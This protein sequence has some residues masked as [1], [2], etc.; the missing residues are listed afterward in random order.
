[1]RD[2]N[3]NFFD[4][5]N[6]IASDFSYEGIES[7][8]ISND[9]FNW[10]SVP[11][12]T[13]REYKDAGGVTIVDYEVAT[14][15]KNNISSYDPFWVRATDKAGNTTYSDIIIPR[16]D[17]IKPEKPTTTLSTTDVV[18][19]S[20]DVTIH[21]E[22]LGSG[23]EY[24]IYDLPYDKLG[25]ITLYSDEESIDSLHS[26]SRSFTVTENCTVEFKIIDKVGNFRTESVSIDNIDNTPPE[27]ITTYDF[28]KTVNSN[29]SIL[30][31]ATDRSDIDSYS[32]RY[33]LNGGN[34]QSSD[35][36]SNTTT[37]NLNSLVNGSNK[38]DIKVKDIFGNEQIVTGKY[39][40]EYDDIEPEITKIELLNS[41]KEILQSSS[42]DIIHFNWENSSLTLKTFT[43]DSSS[44]V[45][46]K[47]L[48]HK[49]KT[50]RGEVIL[51]DTVKVSDIR[52]TFLSILNEENENHYDIYRYQIVAIDSAGNQSIKAKEVT[53]RIDRK[54]P[55]IISSGSL[56]NSKTISEI[57]LKSLP[58]ISDYGTLSSSFSANYSNL[59]YSFDKLTW[60]ALP[61]DLT[62]RYSGVDGSQKLYLRYTDGANNISD[63]TS[64]EFIKDTKGPEFSSL[65]Q[66]DNLG[67]LLD[68][69]LSF[70]SLPSWDDLDVDIDTLQYR[71]D[72]T[73]LDL[74]TADGKTQIDVES[75]PEGF[76]YIYFRVKDDVGNYGEST[77]GLEFIV[78]KT[79]PVADSFTTYIKEDDLYKT[80]TETGFSSDKDV[81][82]AP[83][84]SDRVLD[85]DGDVSYY[86]FYSSRDID[87]DF[88][89]IASIF[90]D[91]KYKVTLLNGVTYIKSVAIDYG[92]N[93]SE[94]SKSLP[95]IIDSVSPSNL[96]IKSTSHPEANS[97][98]DTVALDDAYFSFSADAGMAGIKQYHYKLYKSE[99]YSIF[100]EYISEGTTISKLELVGLEE[101]GYNENTS[102]F[103]Y[104]YLG[105]V[106]ESNNG[107]LSEEEVYTFRV[108]L[109]NPKNIRIDSDTHS[110]DK[111]Y[112]SA[113]K[114]QFSWLEP[115]DL[116]GIKKYYYKF[117]NMETFTQDL[118]EYIADPNNIDIQGWGETTKREKI[119]D[120]QSFVSQGLDKNLECGQVSF[121][122]V[123]EDWTGKKNADYHTV[124]F[125]S[126]KPTIEPITDDDIYLSVD[127]E[128]YENFNNLNFTWGVVEDN[129]SGV[130]RL[131]FS[132]YSLDNGSEL[133][134][135]V[136]SGKEILAP[137][138]N[139]FSV[140]GLDKKIKKYRAQLEIFDKA[141]NKEIKH[142]FFDSEG[143]ID[144]A[145]AYSIPFDNE[146]YGYRVVGQTL[147]DPIAELLLPKAL[148]LKQNSVEITK[149]NLDF[150]DKLTEFKN[151]E[152]KLIELED[153][154]LEFMIRGYALK[155][156]GLVLDELG[157]EIF[158]PYITLPEN[159]IAQFNNN[160]LLSSSKSLSSD[161]PISALYT[162]YKQFDSSNNWVIKS[163][164]DLE[165]ILSGKNLRISTGYLPK[166]SSNGRGFSIFRNDKSVSLVKILLNSNWKILEGDFVGSPADP[167]TIETEN[168]SIKVEK[169]IL[170]ENKIIIADGELI[171]HNQEFVVSGEISNSVRFK[172]LEI[173]YEGIVTK[174][175]SF[176]FDNFSYDYNGTNFS[177]DDIDFTEYGFTTEG[178]FSVG[179]Y[180]YRFSGHTFSGESLDEDIAAKL[181]TRL[182]LD[183]SG[184]SLTATDIEVVG[185]QIEINGGILTLTDTYG[186]ETELS[187]VVKPLIISSLDF[188]VIDEGIWNI[189]NEIKVDHSF[190]S[191]L[192]VKSLGLGSN[193]LDYT[194]MFREIE[195][196]LDDYVKGEPFTLHNLLLDRAGN[197]GDS[198][199][200]NSHKVIIEGFNY[201][202]SNLQYIG[203]DFKITVGSLTLDTANPDE[204]HL[205]GLKFKGLEFSGNG[206]IYYGA[207][208]TVKQI[209][210]D[211]WNYSLAEFEQRADGL[212][213]KAS[214]SLPEEYGRREI[215]FNDFNY[216]PG[217]ISNSGI[218]DSKQFINIGDWRVLA[219]SISVDKNIINIE[220]GEIR[221]FSTMGSQTLLLSSIKLD[222]NGTIAETISEPSNINFI[223]ENGFDVTASSYKLTDNGILLSGQILFPE[224]LQ[225]PEGSVGLNY[226]DQDVLLNG[227]GEII[228]LKEVDE[229]DYFVGAIP[230][231]GY[232]ISIDSDGLLTDE[233]TLKIVGLN[234]HELG[235]IEYYASGEIKFGGEDFTP[236]SFNP[237]GDEVTFTVKS[238]RLTDD[239]I[240][241]S[242]FV[243][244]PENFAAEYIYFDHLTLHGDG[245]VTSD[246]AVPHLE[247]DAFNTHFNFHDIYLNGEGFSIGEGNITLPDT[248]ENKEVEL[249]NFKINSD[250]S[251][252]LGSSRVDP[253]DM[254][255]YTFYID[256]LGF[257][258]LPVNT[259][260]GI[261]FSGGVRLPGD[262]GVQELAGKRF[263]IKEL[264]VPYDMDQ[265]ELRFNLSLDDSIDFR[266]F[267][268]WDATIT[269]ITVDQDFNLIVNE[270]TV[271]LPKEFN[272]NGSEKPQLKIENITIIPEPTGDE[273]YFEV[274]SIKASNLSYRYKDLD[275]A[276]QE[277]ALSEERGLEIT[278]GSVFIP[279]NDPNDP[280]FPE[281]LDNTTLSIHTLQ[282]K[283]DFSVGD[284][285]VSASK[286]ESLPLFDELFYLEPVPTSDSWK[287][288][289]IKEGDDLFLGASARAVLGYDFPT[290]IAGK[291]LNIGDK[292]D[293]FGIKVNVT[294]GS[295]ERFD[296]QGDFVDENGNGFIFTMLENTVETK[297]LGLKYAKETELFELSVT[298]TSITLDAPN[299]PNF[300][301]NTVATVETFTIDQ[302]GKVSNFYSTFELEDR[303]ELFAGIYME[304]WKLGID[305]DDDNGLFTFSTL[306][307]GVNSNLIE[308]GSTFPDGIAGTK[309]S[310]SAFSIDSNGII[311]DIDF[312]VTLSPELKLFGDLN[313]RGLSNGEYDGSKG[314]NLNF[315]K[316]DDGKS[317]IIDLT[318]AAK[319]PEGDALPE[320]IAGLEIP[321]HTFKFDATGKILALDMGVSN[322][323]I[324]IYG[325]LSL[326][327]G[328]INVLYE[329]VGTNDLVFDF[330][331]SIVMP[332][333][334]KD[335]LGVDKFN[336]NDLKVSTNSGLI[337]F[338]AGVEGNITAPL[339]AGM[340][341]VFNDIT[342]SNS[343]ISLVGQL[344]LPSSLAEGLPE[345]ILLEKFVMDWGGDIID[346]SAGI[347][348]ATVT[349]GGF[350]T[351]IT[352]FVVNADRITMDT[353]RIKLPSQM[354]GQK[355]GF[356]N[357]G[358]DY[359]GTFFGEC[360]LDK[361]E[362]PN[363]AGFKIILIE[364]ALDAVNGR[365]SF[366]KVYCKT[367][368]FVGGV[369]IGI[370]GVEVTPSSLNI[371]GGDIALPDFTVGDGMGFKDIK[372]SFSVNKDSY[373]VK[374]GGKLIVPGMG[375]FGTKVSFTNPS[376][377]Y[378]IG[379][380]QA[381]FSWEAPGVGIPM[382]STGM[383]LNG[384]RGGL[385]FGPPI[386]IPSSLR[387]MF[388][389][390]TRIQLGLT[391]VDST[392]GSQVR[393]DADIWLDITDWDWAFRGDLVVLNGTARAEVLAAITG[394][395]FYGK[396]QVTLAV[397]RGTVQVFVYD[398]NGQTIVSGTADVDFGIEKGALFHS[399]RKKLWF[400]TI[401]EVNI[402]SRTEWLAKGYAQFGRFKKGSGWVDGIKGGINIAWFNLN[403]FANSNGKLDLWGA[404]QYT[405]YNPFSR[406]GLSAEKNN[407][408]RIFN[409][410]S[411]GTSSIANSYNFSIP[412][413]NKTKL[414]R[415]GVSSESE[416]V[417][418]LIFLVNY[419]EG[420][421][422]LTAI[423]ADGTEYTVADPNVTVDRT[424]WGM[425]FIVNKPQAGS[426][427]LR[428]DNMPSDDSYSVTVFGNQKQPELFVDTFGYTNRYITEPLTVSGSTTGMEEGQTVELFAREDMNEFTG[429]KIAQTTLDSNGSFSTKIDPS[430]LVD[431][432][433]Y[434]YVSVDNG[435]DANLIEFIGG[436]LL[437]N[438]YKEPLAA[439][440]NILLSKTKDG[441]LVVSFDKLDSVRVAGYS[442]TLTNKNSGV[443]KDFYL[444]QMT[445]FTIPGLEKDDYIA[446]IKA[447][448]SNGAY[449]AQSIAKEISLADVTENLNNIRTERDSIILETNVGDSVTDT[450]DIIVDFPTTT[451]SSY[452]FITGEFNSLTP[453]Q[454]E[455][456]QSWG[457]YPKLDNS[458]IDITS[459]HE[460]LNYTIAT[461]SYTVPGTYSYILTINNMG[462]LDNKI[463]IPL[464]LK[465]THPP[466]MLDSVSP[467]IWSQGETKNFEIYGSGFVD[468][469]KLLLDGVELPTKD[470]TFGRLAADVPFD[471]KQGNRTITV[472]SP[473]GEENTIDVEVEGPTWS[474]ATFKGYSVVN[475][476]NSTKLIF[477]LSGLNDFNSSVPF[478]V[479]NL[480][481]G[482]SSS[483]YTT[484]VLADTLEDILIDVP[485]GTEPGTYFFTI[486][487]IED[488]SIRAEIKVTNNTINPTISSLS[489][490][491]ILTGD[492]LSIFGFGFSETSEV[493]IGDTKQE[494]TGRDLDIL[495]IKISNSTL[496]GDIRVVE[497]TTTSNTISL[498]VK[499]RGY[500]IYPED[501]DYRMQPGESKDV[502]VVIS[503]Y[504]EYVNLEVDN[505][506]EAITAYIAD[507][508]LKLNGETTL[509][510][511]LAH[512]IPNGTYPISIVGTDGDIR[513]EKV[514][515]VQVGDAFVFT[516]QSIPSF[517]EGV[518][519]SFQL[520]TENGEG[521]TQ[522]TLQE[523][524]DLPAGLTL[525]KSGLISGKANFGAENKIVVVLAKDETGRVITKEFKITIEENSWSLSGKDGGNSRY[526]PTPSPADNRVKW[527][528]KTQQMATKILIGNN[529]VFALGDNGINVLSAT[530]GMPLY[531]IDG[532]FS[533]YF[534]SS[535][536]LFTLDKD[537]NFTAWEVSLGNKKWSRDGVTNFSTDGFNLLLETEVETLVINLTDGQLTNQL[538]ITLDNTIWFKNQL[539]R[540]G[541]GS[542]QLLVENSWVE[543]YDSIAD[544]EKVVT[545]SNN[546]VLLSKIGDLTILDENY[547]QVVTKQIILTD[548]ELVLTDKNI[549]ILVDGL[550]H[551]YNKTTL[552]KEITTPTISG[553][554]IS[555][556]EKFFV[557]G[558]RGLEAKNIYNGKNIWTI[559]EPQHDAVI[560]GE[561]LFTI[562]QAGVV[563]CYNG[564]DNIFSPT[565]TIVSNPAT[566]DG[567]NDYYRTT[568]IVELNIND[569]ETFVK[570]GNYKYNSSIFKN[571]TE[572]L[573]LPDGEY[574]FSGYGVDSNGLRGL[575]E[576]RYFKVDTSIP[577][578]TNLIT[579]QEGLNGYT[580]SNVIYN[581]SATD[582][583]SG[584][585]YIHY[586]LNGDKHIY[587]RAVE[588]T[589]EGDYTFSWY[590]EDRA[591]NLEEIKTDER[592]ID[593]NNPTIEYEIYE[594]DEF[595]TVYLS[596]TDSYSG[597]NRIEYRVNGADVQ[598]YLDPINLPAGIMYDITFRSV[599]NAGRDSGWNAIVL[600]LSDVEPVDLIKE[601]KYSWG[602][603]NRYVN[604]DVQVGDPLYIFK[605]RGNE[606]KFGKY[607][608]IESLPDYL[609]GGEMLVGN[610]N[611]K[612]AWDKKFITIT[613]GTTIDLYVLRN[614]YSRLE[615]DDTWTLVDSDV[616]ISQYAF[617]GGADIYHRVVTADNYATIT[618]TAM[619]Q[620]GGANIV[621]AKRNL[622]ADLTIF[623]PNPSKD[624]TPLSFNWYSASNIKG[625]INRS[626]SYK[627]GDNQEVELGSN[628]SGEFNLPYVDEDT[629]LELIVKVEANNPVDPTIT[630]TITTSRFYNVINRGEVKILEPVSGSQVL[631]NRPTPI[632]YKVINFNN[633]EIEANIN[634]SVD[635]GTIT[636][637][638]L[639][640]NITGLT[641]ITSSFNIYQDYIKESTTTLNIVDNYTTETFDF[642]QNLVTTYQEQENG[643]FYGFNKDYRHRVGETTYIDIPEGKYWSNNKITKEYIAFEDGDSFEYLVNNGLYRVKALVGPIVRYDKQSITIEGIKTE[644]P[645]ER[646]SRYFYIELTA[647]VVDNKLTITGS[648]NLQL[649]ELEVTRVEEPIET[650]I[651]KLENRRVIKDMK[652]YQWNPDHYFPELDWFNSDKKNKYNH[653]TNSMR[654][655]SE[656][657]PARPS[658]RGN[659]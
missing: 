410:D 559:Q 337:S 459:G 509:S 46:Y 303:R 140:I 285:S 470:K 129:K 269:G 332:T 411:R 124:Y 352:N 94:L 573:N 248:M 377:L 232:G 74:T 160:L 214:L 317:F 225:N 123:A 99:F 235:P 207:S 41:D 238:I 611:D 134:F 381:Y 208:D 50:K 251:F 616:D 404:S 259:V 73:W 29:V 634:W 653:R 507:S 48:D 88:S 174:G 5:E 478:T 501:D 137:E 328:T 659:R 199:V 427:T 45:N 296:V 190:G 34:W 166:E 637:N 43:N 604:R 405:L 367:P 608:K 292:A 633:E 650:T 21:A 486:D 339:F 101:N 2:V 320:G 11:Y 544:I 365:V 205:N 531:T 64:I 155:S 298:G 52:P 592:I 647:D 492:E 66:L 24:I 347:S 489:N 206:V 164:E 496:S 226:P 658:D 245:T 618:G 379:L 619:W 392:G 599:D 210:K 267:D 250:G 10:T 457:I 572:G 55:V 539:Y 318:A 516:T 511:T 560:V 316:S 585:E 315:L 425:Y 445:K 307:S 233:N 19:G 506:S 270:G 321:V 128:D 284:L 212:Y 149:V 139:T 138:T 479:N 293:E 167:F 110:I 120:L 244:L 326:E 627:L 67:Y 583:T 385:T 530:S 287:L 310:I 247:F 171:V 249:T 375:T 580:I 92:G 471:T 620:Q 150:K 360:V 502:N 508:Y 651:T 105:V 20:L 466:V 157:L 354:G 401:P 44:T 517:M 432:E 333:A 271:D 398:Q 76:Y 528:T 356:N 512:S 624:L 344:N 91:G 570:E 380:E 574:S 423:A 181:E 276:L 417:D 639:L 282:I 399:K 279:E 426:W 193:G 569:P 18:K 172:D 25:P 626:W 444:G 513:V 220:S 358:F 161:K 39:M 490:Y 100:S 265:G 623:S 266:I 418:T 601:F 243:T 493:Y 323:N 187:D 443:S 202:A 71:I 353:F 145:P 615:L 482:W 452:D 565:T 346:I 535:E 594:D 27:I 274:K 130:E 182:E 359:N 617:V 348:N 143:I 104:Y 136:T 242:S 458:L 288:A 309:S 219:D 169:A 526:N 37:L 645:T 141:G 252:E 610:Y 413:E 463:E 122:L 255:G 485:T 324:D 198:D 602:S 563:T 173:S 642:G 96:K 523:E 85:R 397:V 272:S 441:D 87:G 196:A 32:W 433:N 538:D 571:Y 111:K 135:P 477:S 228:T 590:A 262:F 335:G 456:G 302:N 16:V 543:V 63:P 522:Y 467:A 301:K 472:V 606:K 567:N 395:G 102:V 631:N 236:F 406:S 453:E 421:P 340:D 584:V 537:N 366:D 93:R 38:I 614:K 53:V 449:G 483:W 625:Q 95:V 388:D 117:V 396:L 390:G 312:D 260:D 655:W 376:N 51:D 578:T 384:I 341:F 263:S 387:S 30:F 491:S 240:N 436:S 49:Y 351:D 532:E 28:D 116:T 607:N 6:H 635:N 487:D 428:V 319:L 579:A 239:G 144:T 648:Q 577:V 234:G 371:S 209:T 657:V 403:V 588:I 497:G 521:E 555:A 306:P 257:G 553:T 264:E 31:I 72:D 230:L 216:T 277:L 629:T 595:S 638:Q 280:K 15:N 612:Y 600:D 568:P 609:I 414:T 409:I 331:G 178:S 180:N 107:K 281:G 552:D 364:P 26:V 203:S 278:E 218:T 636:N 464:T 630:D 503:G 84:G 189:D 613:A 300:L 554:I 268:Q 575:T 191:G 494:V 424:E 622:A 597:V 505:Q 177:V 153:N 115:K 336:I 652:W 368:D 363:I 256:D 422:E 36:S 109:S 643:R 641:T 549:L 1:M 253:F 649:L 186:G 176:S 370:N 7:F 246:T 437:I 59:E 603:G 254:W 334:V 525:S 582:E 586:E 372:V 168:Y 179:D 429:Y 221:L 415:S 529:K 343:G 481:E 9:E 430:T 60:T 640:P 231:R 125:D 142:L 524:D 374:G 223:S 90:E 632:N 473:S 465:V 547:K 195:L 159:R 546:I 201:Q 33:S 79:S 4:S 81:Y 295:I 435:I 338:E 227:Y 394:R 126:E 200:T 342:V 211:G 304:N 213:S 540:T 329:P 222:S 542:L 131:T 520:I 541:K 440:D 12:E 566:P 628:F 305:M 241:L 162:G 373:Y 325:E 389:N 165:F 204:K 58:L 350:T 78:D 127:I 533:D 299:L 80:I 322:L 22:D 474:I 408:D 621:I 345:S 564:R 114:A 510:I 158:E 57:V 644:I 527:N 420:D 35:G 261:S 480:P 97:E 495:T 654:V 13:V 558:D 598:N 438:N 192:T 215:T 217:G 112:Y 439:V 536:T 70:K 393:G 275:F 593:L 545:D 119:F 308:L 416:D 108:D 562:D 156:Y 400:V 23:V 450:V 534:Y 289:L 61:E 412:G 518:D 311:G 40:L 407:N 17:T 121:I 82:L 519:S 576:S 258:E 75:R 283:N 183:Y 175:K 47:L 349:V 386:E 498:H 170:R 369:E 391:V 455:E 561:E 163:D 106:A 151:G 357:A 42:Q 65:G 434:I 461:N 378:P 330:G 589:E 596:A 442:L 551:I 548:G 605:N 297:G 488:N 362:S 118:D 327:D 446:T 514:I 475:P 197:L 98:R 273:K 185:S 8:E 591:G 499:E 500:K 54:K 419:G 581:L 515:E 504:S 188:S 286:T 656:Q 454:Y 556:K 462:N 451:N 152:Y 383:F 103:E 132:L 154:P 77:E 476:G 83:T 448:D 14:I 447:K 355:V 294:T 469:T 402:P 113:T 68:G 86:E 237:I 147:V 557:A 290:G 460:T 194:I 550:T 468:G 291:A 431:G 646:Q 229:V 62:V 484:N 89:P 146:Y 184:Y 148:G 361:I 314:A 313:V 56:V 133:I 587:S 224:A 382:A 3:N 69:K